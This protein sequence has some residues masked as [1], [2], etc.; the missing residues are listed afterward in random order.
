[1]F[2]NPDGPKGRFQVRIKDVSNLLEEVPVREKAAVLGEPLDH[3]AGP[4]LSKGEM[5]GMEVGA[6]ILESRGREVPQG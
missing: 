3:T 5:R 2:V 6:D 1:M 4:T